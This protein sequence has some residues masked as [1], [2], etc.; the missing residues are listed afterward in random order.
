MSII[1]EG[2]DITKRFDSKS[3]NEKLTI[4]NSTNIQI[5][6]GSVVTV[7]GASGCGKSTLLHILG[8]LDQPDEGSVSWNGQSIYEMDKKA[9]AEFRNTKLGFVFQF[10]HLL[11]E[12]TALE[13][14]MMPSLIRGNT[15]DET[16]KRARGLLEDF[17]IPGRAEHRPTQLSGGEQQR[18]AMARALINNPDLILADEPTGNLDEENTE[19]LL[20]LLFDLR[21]EE[22]VSLLLITH[23]KDIARRSDIIYELSKGQLHEL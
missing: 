9:L 18:V 22:D 5:E 19:I 15:A 14:I 13:N 21:E 8:G 10:H 7:V 17:G 16:E 20:K 1:L 2:N 3:G 12:F 6:K 4:L 11:P 23:E